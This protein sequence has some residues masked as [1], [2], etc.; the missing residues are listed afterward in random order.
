MAYDQLLDHEYDGIREYDNPCPGWWHGLFWAT[1][2]FSILYFVF[3]QVGTFGWTLA[4]SYQAA[5]AENVKLRFG[6]IGT[7]KPDEPT[8]LAYMHKPDWLAVG[9]AVFAGNCVSCHG[10]D[11]SGLVG[12]NL[13]DDYYKNVKTLADVARVVN[14]GA[15]GGSMP[16]WRT[17]L[18][19]NEVVLVAA[20]VASLR[21]K[22][23]PGPRG[24][25]GELIPPWPE[26]SPAVKTP[27]STGPS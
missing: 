3:F 6:E 21:G 16:A 20:Y 24:K 26:P 8:L 13:T 12:P 18:H 5:V 14:D 22:N 23:L 10:A 15:A 17:R 11:G 9:A 7:L 2:L 27:K 25:E 19:P 1:I 4:D